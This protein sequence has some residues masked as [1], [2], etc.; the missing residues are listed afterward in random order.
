MYVQYGKPKRFNKRNQEL[1][2]HCQQIIAKFSAMGYTLTVRQLYYQL[3]GEGILEEEGNNDATYKSICRLVR[4]AREGGLI[5]WKAIEDRT[6]GLRQLYKVKDPLEALE[7][8]LNQYHIDLWEN[9]AYRVEVWVEKDA[10]LN[11]VAKI[12]NQ[13]DVPYISCRGYMSASEIWLAGFERFKYYIEEEHKTPL[14]IQLS[15]LDP[16]GEDMYRDIKKRLRTYSGHDILVNRVALTINQVHQ[17]NLPPNYAKLSDT[18]AKDFIAKYGTS[19]YELDALQPHVIAGLIEEGI[20]EV[21]DDSLWEDAL[22][23]KVKD[24]QKIAGIIAQY[25]D[26]LI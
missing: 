19:S 13:Y 5:S 22:E 2:T 20:K 24:A 16:S 1:L 23:Q 10:L 26:T 17:Y 12:A 9:Q 4:R 25:K 11:V 18:R 21:L 8:T 14:V 7:D 15:D 6:R 3:V